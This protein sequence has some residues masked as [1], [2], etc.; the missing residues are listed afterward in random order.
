MC[1]LALIFNAAQGHSGQNGATGHTLTY[2]T[3][4]GKQPLIGYLL[5]FGLHLLDHLH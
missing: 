2:E 3:R 5:V 4:S 1:F